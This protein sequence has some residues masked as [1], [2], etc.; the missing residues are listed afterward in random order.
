MV[1]SWLSRCIFGDADPDQDPLTKVSTPSSPNTPTAITMPQAVQPQQ[2][3]KFQ[4]SEEPEEPCLSQES[5]NSQES[6]E[7]Q[8]SQESQETSG[9]LVLWKPPID[10]LG[11]L[12]TELILVIS[13]FLPITCVA[14]LALTCRR[15]AS[16]FDARTLASR[17]NKMATQ[18]VVSRLDGE[19]LGMSYCAVGQR[20]AQFTPHTLVP[21]HFCFHFHPVEKIKGPLHFQLGQSLFHLPWCAARLVTN[22]YTLGPEYGLPALVLNSTFDHQHEEYGVRWREIWEAKVIRG[23]LVLSCTHILSHRDLTGRALNS[24]LGSHA[25][26]ACPHKKLRVSIWSLGHVQRYGRGCC[27]HCGTDWAISMLRRSGGRGWVAKTKIYHLLGTCRSPS[28]PKWKSM[29][30]IFKSFRDV[31]GGTVSASWRGFSSAAAL[32]P[33]VSRGRCTVPT[34]LP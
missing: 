9:P 14:C 2:P 19:I 22:Y 29:T 25:I 34:F 23:N 1:C 4:Q 32:V 26:T 24:Y 13:E 33:T 17:L 3:E 27:W 31:P 8:E 30:S 15:M 28:D 7:A 20:L 21:Q 5:Q 16:I 10:R 18:I 6:Q 11:D 12:P